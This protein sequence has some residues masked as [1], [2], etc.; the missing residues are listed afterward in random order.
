MTTDLRTTLECYKE[1]N[2]SAHAG[3]D[4]AIK[5][6]YGRSPRRYTEKMTSLY[7]SLGL[8]NHIHNQEETRLSNVNY[9]PF[10]T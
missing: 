7:T 10:V 3:S 2:S 9:P 1:P 4:D 5:L 6:L 8:Y